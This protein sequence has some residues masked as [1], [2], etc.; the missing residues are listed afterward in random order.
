MQP[1]EEDAGQ[2]RW[3]E[4]C[5]DL[6]RHQAATAGAW[7]IVV[8]A[9]RAAFTGKPNAALPEPEVAMANYRSA[10]VVQ[11][12]AEEAMQA[13]VDAHGPRQAE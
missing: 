10:R 9:Y 12:V 3:R 6:D 13:H 5:A 8:E 2:A 7:S 1:R 11:Q 4:L